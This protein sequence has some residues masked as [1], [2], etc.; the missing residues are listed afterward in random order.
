LNKVNT[1]NTINK[2]CKATTVVSGGYTNKQ[3]IPLL[4][5]D[6]ALFGK[7]EN[8]KVKTLKPE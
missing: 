4:I 1:N 3:I 8:E 5:K 6:A 7:I 2:S